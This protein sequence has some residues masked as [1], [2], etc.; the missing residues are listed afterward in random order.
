MNNLLLAQSALKPLVS[1]NPFRAST[2]NPIPRYGA[3]PQR[4]SQTSVTSNNEG[5]NPFEFET[6]TGALDIDFS[7]IGVTP[8][9]SGHSTVNPTTP[10][11][12]RNRRKST[13][14]LSLY[15]QEGHA[16]PSNPFSEEGPSY[17]TTH[18]NRQ[19]FQRDSV[20][21]ALGMSDKAYR[22]WSPLG[23]DSGETSRKESFVST[24]SGPDQGAWEGEMAHIES[25]TSKS[26]DRMLDLYSGLAM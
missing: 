11:T 14:S 19:T 9:P 5:V 25:R 18:S 15:S 24:R 17:Q 1:N 20:N 3:T 22:P 13:S 23:I 7:R 2:A 8:V 16:A 10:I 12:P 26:F 21:E 6:E 4:Y